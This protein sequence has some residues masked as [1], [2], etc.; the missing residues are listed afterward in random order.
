MKRF[1]EG[2]GMKKY[3]ALFGLK[4]SGE[5]MNTQK[6]WKKT[7]SLFFFFGLLILIVATEGWSHAGSLKSIQVAQKRVDHAW[8]VYHT[9]AL[10]GTLASPEIQMRIEK[11]L[12][13]ARTRL[14]EARDAKEAKQKQMLREKLDEIES[15]TERVIMDSQEQKR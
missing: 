9:A 6:K 4:K 3:K 1:R 15:I 14:V 10:S 7:A 5:K 2:E 11:D 13:L 12:H 8:E